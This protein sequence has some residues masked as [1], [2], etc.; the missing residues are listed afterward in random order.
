MSVIAPIATA[1]AWLNNRRAAA[2]GVGLAAALSLA[3]LSNTQLARIVGDGINNSVAGIKTVAAMLA[4]RSPGQRPDGAL[5]SLKHKRQAA[6]HERALPKIRGPVPPPSPYAALLGA[7]VSP[8]LPPPPEVPLYNMVAGTPPVIVPGTGTPVG[9]GGPPILSEI[10]TPGGGGGVFSPPV[11]A[12]TPESPPIPVTPVPEPASWAMM[13]IGFA[14][15]AR[16]LRRVASPALQH[17]AD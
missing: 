3:M 13:L 8:P 4:E 11:V 9:G 6:L 10:P 5:A 7:P 14:M 2:A 17:T 15:M 16:S 1:P 12:S